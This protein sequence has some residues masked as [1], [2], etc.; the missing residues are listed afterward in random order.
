MVYY[1]DYNTATDDYSSI[2]SFVSIYSWRFFANNYYYTESRSKE[3]LIGSHFVL[4]KTN[5]VKNP[6]VI[7]LVKL[8]ENGEY[9]VAMNGDANTVTEMITTEYGLAVYGLD[10]GTYYLIQT[11]VPDGYNKLVNPVKV[12]LIPRMEDGYIDGVSIKTIGIENSK[13]SALIPEDPVILPVTGG[14]GTVIMITAGILLFVLSL[15][16][17]ITKLRIKND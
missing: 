3:A 6:E 11:S 15:C 13:V 17:V 7:S 4:S 16:A 10:G 1:S 2:S 12:E 8:S 9:R 14:P 5:D